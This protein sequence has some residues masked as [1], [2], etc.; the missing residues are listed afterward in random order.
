[1]CTDRQASAIEDRHLYSLFNYSGKAIMSID[2]QDS[3]G[4]QGGSEDLYN[5]YVSFFGQAHLPKSDAYSLVIQWIAGPGRVHWMEA[6]LPVKIEQAKGETIEIYM[7]PDQFV[8]ASLV[9]ESHETYRKGDEAALARVN[10]DRSELSCVQPTTLPDLVPQSLKGFKQDSVTHSWSQVDNSGLSSLTYQHLWHTTG[11]V[12]FRLGDAFRG[13]PDYQDEFN[14]I[15]PIGN[16]A[17][18]LI[19]SPRAGYFVVL[20]DEKSW[21]S[22]VLGG[23]EGDEKVL[24]N[25]HI[26][27]GNKSVLDS[28]TGTFYMLPFLT[29]TTEK[30]MSESSDGKYLATYFYIEDSSNRGGKPTFAGFGLIAL[31][32]GSVKDISGT[33]LPDIPPGENIWTFAENWY[34]AH[35]AWA[36]QGETTLVCK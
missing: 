13:G 14:S 26:L 29:D 1:M 27:L 33:N 17:A 12:K 21:S 2:I 30:I 28:Q 8:C 20:G 3:A 9:D 15:R 25:T 6:R 18:L 24:S 19:A 36:K 16:E 31:E 10:S 11:Q 22:R 34:Q 23:G 35:C 5:N 32:D 7:R 4:G